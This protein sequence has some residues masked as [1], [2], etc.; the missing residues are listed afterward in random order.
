MSLLSVLAMVLVVALVV[1]LVMPGLLGI[2]AIFTF[3]GARRN[4]FGLLAAGTFAVAVS[5]LLLAGLYSSY[6]AKQ[7]N[8]FLG[9]GAF[10]AWYLF[11]GTTMLVG[12]L[13]GLGLNRWVGVVLFVTSVWVQFHI[14]VGASVESP[15]GGGPM[16]LYAG[17]CIGACVL[18][19]VVRGQWLAAL[20][21]LLT[22]AVATALVMALYGAHGSLAVY[23]Q[24]GNDPNFADKPP[25]LSL[26]VAMLAVVLGG[27]LFWLGRRRDRVRAVAAQAA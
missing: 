16:L 27:A 15:E 24:L 5:A 2:I 18:F 7:D 11:T 10:A 26:D 13:V 6:F 12:S 25:V 9:N 1:A 14:P 8:A 17:I 22:A 23:R 3:G 20:I 19:A 21:G 4:A